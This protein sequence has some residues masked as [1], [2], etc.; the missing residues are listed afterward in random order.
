M[1]D[2]TDE[3]LDQQ[4]ASRARQ[5]VEAVILGD[6]VRDTGLGAGF[7][8]APGCLVIVAQ[9]LFSEQVQAGGK[10]LHGD[11]FVDSWRGYV[12][13]EVGLHCFEGLAEVV[14][15]P[16][17]G[18]AEVVYGTLAVG[19]EGFNAGDDIDTRLLL[20]LAEPIAAPAAQ[21]YEYSFHRS[22]FSFV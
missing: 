1:A 8:Y 2:R 20:A 7:D 3:V 18:K 14:V 15:Y 9:G 19:R 4:A 13:D 16:V 22:P 12:E 6:H 5:A 21:S 10:S 17:G 11:F